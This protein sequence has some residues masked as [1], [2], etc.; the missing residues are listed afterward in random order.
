MSAATLDPT[1]IAVPRHF[2]EIPPNADISETEL[3]AKMLGLPLTPQGRNEAA[4][5]GARDPEGG[6]L[7]KTCVIQ[8]PRRSTKS[9]SIW[10]TIIGRA[11]SRPKYKAVVTAQSGTVASALILEHGELLE[12][13]GYAGYKRKELDEAE[14]NG[15]MRVLR[16][17]G[18]EKLEFANGSVIVV[19][20]PT[21]AAVRSKA[22]DDI[23]IDEAGEFDGAKGEEF[24]NG[25]LPLMDTRGERAQ[26]IIA[27]TPGKMRVGMFWELLEAGRKGD[28]D[29][30]GIL[31]YSASDEDYATLNPIEWDKLTP[32]EQEWE[33]ELWRRVH[34]GPSAIK[35]DGTPLTSMRTLERRRRQM[36]FPQFV[37]EY[38]CVWPLD[39]AT[40]AL[41]MEAWGKLARPTPFMPDKF[42]WAFDVAPDGSSSALVAAWREENGEGWF[43]VM[44][45]R[46]GTDWLMEEIRK[47]QRAG[48]THP[49]VYDR[50]GA[51]MEV[52]TRLETDR[53]GLRSK[54]LFFMQGVVPAEAAF[55][56]ELR[57]GR[58]RH[59]NQVSLNQALAGATWRVTEGARLWG[60]KA[61]SSDL[62]P[63]VA[64]ALAL[65][66][67]DTEVHHSGDT[68]E[69]TSIFG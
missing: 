67:Y 27:G 43:E 57:E 12:A 7:Y 68:S 55:V 28:D 11:A 66:H 32:D 2:S 14:G 29:Y 36:T 5:L 54:G 47:V 30:M 1:A 20:P 26:L 46:P 13:N 35:D 44:D 25:V 39:A 18:R 40:S 37:R 17:G 3:G 49:V 4:L 19:V 21:P 60:R 56:R 42:A 16:N 61:S 45:H 53:Q 33:R 23:V 65:H 64:A 22:A 69:L 51:N 8:M 62:S 34:P 63:A 24:M 10:A 58:L 6:S 38:L 9:T 41:D 52:A 59:S 31:D 15:T 50:I 48:Q